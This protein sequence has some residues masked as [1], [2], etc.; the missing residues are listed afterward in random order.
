MSIEDIVSRGLQALIDEDDHLKL[1]AADVSPARLARTLADFKPD[2][3]I[4][5]FG[6]LSTP[7]G[8]IG[9]IADR[10]HL[11]AASERTHR[12]TVAAS[13]SRS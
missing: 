2:V 13:R 12:S 1:V 11:T 3:A 8:L 4:L 7:A 9:R 10:V 5:N 6:S